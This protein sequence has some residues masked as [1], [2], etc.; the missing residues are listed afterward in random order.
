M[1]AWY[2]TVVE[3]QR[4]ACTHVSWLRESHIIKEVSLIEKVSENDGVDMLWHLWSLC[5]SHHKHQRA[6]ALT[7]F[8]T[9]HHIHDQ[10]FTTLRAMSHHASFHCVNGGC[11][12]AVSR[13]GCCVCDVNAI[14]PVP[15]CY[16]YQQLSSITSPPKL[17]LSSRWLCHICICALVQHGVSV[18]VEYG[19]HGYEFGCHPSCFD[20]DT[21]LLAPSLL[22]ACCCM[23]RRNT[24]T[25]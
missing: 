2:S 21:Q 13:N 6:L 16:A 5:Q 10:C 4:H 19:I 9:T 11:N 22:N 25:A 18:G 24:I 8:P 12:S 17:D 23:T 1:I 20:Y 7:Q 15:F 3:C 14:R